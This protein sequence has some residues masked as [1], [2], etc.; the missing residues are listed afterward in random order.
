VWRLWSKRIARSLG[1][2]LVQADLAEKRSQA[3]RPESKAGGPQPATPGEGH[4][5]TMVEIDDLIES[6]V[7]L[8][9]RIFLA[10]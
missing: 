2:T 5:P 7:I 8:H 6:I 1:Q 10:H 4:L 9:Y 3:N